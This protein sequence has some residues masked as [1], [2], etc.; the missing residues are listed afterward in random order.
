[1]QSPS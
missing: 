1:M